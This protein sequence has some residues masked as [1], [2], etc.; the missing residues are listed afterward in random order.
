MSESESRPAGLWASAS[1]LVHTLLGVVEARV[2]LFAVEWQEQKIRLVEI[3]VLTSVAVFLGGLALVMLTIT[4]LFACW[5]DPQT[6]LIAMIVMTALYAAVAGAAAWRLNQV[7]KNLSVPFS[8]T[9]SQFKKDR[10]WL[11][12]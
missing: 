5:S 8:E 10:S 11:E 7:L 6:R 9:L 4:V 3:L 1:R 12:N 2:E